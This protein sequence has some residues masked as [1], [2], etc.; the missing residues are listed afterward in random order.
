MPSLS[1]SAVRISFACVSPG[2]ST[3]DCVTAVRRVLVHPHLARLLLRRACSASTASRRTPATLSPSTSPI[4]ISCTNVDGWRSTSSTPP[5][6]VGMQRRAM[7]PWSCVAI[8]QLGLAVA[9]DVALLDVAEAIELAA[10]RRVPVRHAASTRRRRSVHVFRNA[11]LR[12]DRQQ[13]LGRLHGLVEDVAVGILETLAIQPARRLPH[14]RE[15]RR[16]GHRRRLAVGTDLVDELRLGDEERGIRAAG[17]RVATRRCGVGRAAGAVRR[18]APRPVR[19]SSVVAASSRLAAR[20]HA[21]DDG[22]HAAPLQRTKTTGDSHARLA[23]G[24][25]RESQSR[26][27]RYTRTSPSLP[28]A[29]ASTRAPRDRDRP[30]DLRGTRAGAETTPAAGPSTPRSTCT[31]PVARSPRAAPRRRSRPRRARSRHRRSRSARARRRASAERLARRAIEDEHQPG[32]ASCRRGTAA[33]TTTWRASAA[34]SEAEQPVGSRRGRAP[35]PAHRPRAERVRRHHARRVLGSSAD[36]RIVSGD[37]D[38]RA[39]ARAARARLGAAQREAQARRW[40][41]RDPDRAGGVDAVR[42]GRTARRRRRPSRASASA[43]PNSF[44]S[45]PACGSCSVCDGL[46]VRRRR[47]QHRARRPARPTARARRPRPT[48]ERPKSRLAAG[49]SSRANTPPVES[50]RKTRAPTLC[51]GTPTSSAARAARERGREVAASLL[52]SIAR[53]CGA[54]RRHSPPAACA[55]R[56]QEQERQSSPHAPTLDAAA[57]G[58]TLALLG[59]VG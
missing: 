45:P 1:T 5:V 21:D 29:P 57:D 44:T 27:R 59:V 42:V 41:D 20:E 32:V 36:D 26:A 33:P 40:R 22:E 56:R 19:S 2:A 12:A 52:R 13:A 35:R 15:L 24:S 55:S 6:L 48:T 3:I 50:S 30:A 25:T 47:R 11:L 18:R 38:R 7:T 46:A 43:R 49:A 28:A 39:E 16:A 58:V 9:V 34:T 54:S 51:A 31:A 4:S 14:D 10:E 8:T 23:A 17:E 53:P 37:R